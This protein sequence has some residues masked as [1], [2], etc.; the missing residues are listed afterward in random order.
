MTGRDCL[1]GRTY[2]VC[3]PIPAEGL[4]SQRHANTVFRKIAYICMIDTKTT[5]QI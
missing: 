5:T 3:A 4:S 2:L 1:G